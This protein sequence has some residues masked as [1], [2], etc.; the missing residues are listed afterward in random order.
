MGYARVNGDVPE[1]QVQG[2]TLQQFGVFRLDM[3]CKGLVRISKSSAC[4]SYTSSGCRSSD[5]SEVTREAKMMQMQQE[6]EV[7]GGGRGKESAAGHR[8]F[9]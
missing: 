7:P 9:P 3:V 6:I 8:R 2:Y 5:T 1:S 4:G